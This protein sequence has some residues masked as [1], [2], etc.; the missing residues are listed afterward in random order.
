MSEPSK[1]ILKQFIAFQ[2]AYFCCFNLGGNLDFPDLL[3]RKFY[4]IISKGLFHKTLLILKLWILTINF[5][6]KWVVNPYDFSRKWLQ[7][8]NKNLNGIGI[9]NFIFSRQQ[10]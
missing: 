1:T 3:Q 9:W 4:E 7:N 5:Y 2:M 6:I 10:Y 8:E